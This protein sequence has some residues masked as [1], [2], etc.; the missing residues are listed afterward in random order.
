LNNSVKKTLGSV[1]IVVAILALLSAFRPPGLS[2]NGFAGVVIFIILFPTGIYF[3]VP[4]ENPNHNRIQGDQNYPKKLTSDVPKQKVGSHVE[5]EYN[6]GSVVYHI[7]PYSKIYSTNNQILE[8]TQYLCKKCGATFA[9]KSEY[10]PS[11]GRRLGNET[12]IEIAWLV[13]FFSSMAL[14]SLLSVYGNSPSPRAIEIS[15]ASLFFGI[16]LWFCSLV[17]AISS[18][19]KAILISVTLVFGFIV[20]LVLIF[21]VALATMAGCPGC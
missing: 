12:A 1:L 20:A 2:G 19:E 15:S 17:L 18:K 7:W 8:T 14:A 16:A 13:T 3:I 11:C 21:F 5:G 10:C 6:Q 9:T 4:D